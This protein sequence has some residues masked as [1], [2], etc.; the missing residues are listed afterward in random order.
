MSRFSLA[1][2]TAAACAGALFVI[3]PAA[4]QQRIDYEAIVRILREC[5]KI[6]DVPARVACYDNNVGIELQVAGNEADRRTP[7]PVL[8]VRPGGFAA[9]T[10]PQSPAERS[11]VTTEAALRV[12]A[13]D[14]LA[15]RV[16]RMTLEDGGIWELIEAMPLS[17]DP[18]RR[19]ATITLNRGSLGGFLMEYAGQPSVRIRRIR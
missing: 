16:Y 4:A 15:P 13:I 10:L 11:A 2:S 14:E 9:D 12:T 18:P 7:A 1:F 5:A 3:T 19:G 6:A 17:F 8:P